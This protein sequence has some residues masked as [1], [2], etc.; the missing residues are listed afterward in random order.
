[1]KER[2]CLRCQSA[3]MR[4]MSSGGYY[5]CSLKCAALYGE[6]CAQDYRWCEKHEEWH[7]T[8]ECQ[9]CVIEK[10]RGGA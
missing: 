10:L 9:D 2:T 7:N 6:R 1:M 3:A 5:F 8:L 4:P